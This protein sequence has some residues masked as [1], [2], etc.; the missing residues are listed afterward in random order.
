[1]NR[2]L[3]PDGEAA[4]ASRL[5]VDRAIEE[6][7]QTRI[8]L[9]RSTIDFARACMQH[10]EQARNETTIARG[11]RHARDGYELAC[12]LLSENRLTPDGTASV[13]EQLSALH[14]EI[15]DAEIRQRSTGHVGS[16]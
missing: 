3:S 16:R 7:Q 9:L 12:R 8:A 5:S 13:R 10:A 2:L 4:K 6:V 11:L 15:D 14:R 1:M